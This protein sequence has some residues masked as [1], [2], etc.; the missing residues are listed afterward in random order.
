MVRLIGR[1]DSYTWLDA[2]QLIKHAFGIA[3]TL[4]GRHATLLHL[5]WEPANAEVHSGLAAHREEISEFAERVQG[6]SPTFRAM[7]YPELW[8][9]WTCDSANMPEWVHRHVGNLRSRYLVHV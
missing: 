8:H 4:N 5:F 6:S 3:R 9:S 1:P 7:S 2:A